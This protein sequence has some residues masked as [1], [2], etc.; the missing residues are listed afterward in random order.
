MTQSFINEEYMTLVE[1][2]AEA[3]GEK[4]VERKFIVEAMCRF[5]RGEVEAEKYPFGAPSLRAIYD[6]AIELSKKEV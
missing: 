3:R 4:P 2:T 5:E 1:K 6:L